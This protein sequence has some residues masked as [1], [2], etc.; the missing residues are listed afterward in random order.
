[1]F[2]H[3]SS[4]DNLMSGPLNLTVMWLTWRQ[5]FARRR[6]WLS[7]L[8]SLAPL[9]FALIFKVVADDGGD[10]RVKFFT[11]LEQDV[12]MGTLLALGGVIF[13]T[14]AFGGEVDDG[15]LVYLLIKPVARWKIALSKLVVASLAA[16]A[17]T[18]PGIV[19]PWLVLRD[20]ALPTQIP[21]AFLAASAA[22]SLI[23]C[24]LFLSLGLMTK[25]ALVGGLLYV[26]L[27]EGVL[28]RS[29]AGFKSLSVREFAIS[30]AHS[31]SGAAPSVPP[32]TV[33]ISTVRAMSVF[34]VV[35]AT[36]WTIRK[37]SRYE[38]A[39]RL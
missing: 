13:G 19:L 17:V 37:V 15:T 10:S 21:L 9:L 39:E 14:T 33:P 4:T 23:Y 3:I 31:L 38:L 20:A 25:R 35:V 24:A 7:V 32:T 5:M 11:G 16:F 29:F 36:A 18:V 6:L 22:G 1:V 27:F 34:I 8:F 2:S 28:V 12:V 30:I 26:I